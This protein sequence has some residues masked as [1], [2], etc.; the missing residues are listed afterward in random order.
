MNTSSVNFFLF[1]SIFFFFF[2]EKER[3]FFISSYVVLLGIFPMIIWGSKQLW[4][5][6]LTICNNRLFL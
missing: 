3:K 1:F 5:H 2:G 4:H 6:L